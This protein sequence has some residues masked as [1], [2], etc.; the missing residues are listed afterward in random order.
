[1]PISSIQATI[2]KL[3]IRP[4]SVD[5]TM[6]GSASCGPEEQ[7]GTLSPS[8]DSM[9]DVQLLQDPCP[10]ADSQ[11]PA[12]LSPSL[13][14]PP[15]S[16]PPPN[17]LDT[18]SPSSPPPSNHH[19]VPEPAPSSISPPPASSASSLE[20]LASLTP[21]AFSL[22]G[23]GRGKQRVTKQNFLQPAEG[24]GIHGT[25]GDDGSDP[26]SSLDPL[27]SLNKH[28]NKSRLLPFS[29][30]TSRGQQKEA[31]LLIPLLKEIL[32]ASDRLWWRLPRCAC[33]PAVATR[34]S[35]HRWWILGPGHYAP[36][37]LRLL[38]HLFAAFLST[39]WTDAPFQLQHIGQPKKRMH[40]SFTILFTWG[41]T[42]ATRLLR[43]FGHLW[44]VWLQ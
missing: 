31:Y 35:F 1:M 32:G 14:S 38:S 9:G 42:G 28:W 8:P 12:S 30:F 25:R 36:E 44:E 27:W 11:P 21:E 37:F 15:H 40:S 4:P 29:R 19:P 22:E 24:Q 39:F 41:C 2:A 10:P 23:G 7:F 5:P 18:L 17:S 34:F 3:S 33:W 20:L 26:L 13:T 6:E 43:I 16:P